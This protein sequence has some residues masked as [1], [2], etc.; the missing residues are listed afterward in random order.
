[1]KRTLLN[2]PGLSAPRGAYSH[3]VKVETAGATF[4]YLTGQLA[5]DAEGNTV[6]PFDVARQTEF[7]FAQIGT[8]LAEAGL[9][10]ED[11]VR[12]QTYLLDLNEYSKF[13]PVRD[14]YFGQCRP[15]STLL[16]VKGLARADTVVEVEITAVK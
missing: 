16:E 6:A 15:A 2:P 3:G 5:I 14:R 11:V 7:I 1:M 13:T 10:Y 4:V 12:S 9:G 8:L